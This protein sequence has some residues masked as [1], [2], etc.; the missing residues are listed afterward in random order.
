MNIKLRKVHQQFGNSPS[1][2]FKHS[3][4]KVVVMVHNKKTVNLF[5]GK[6]VVNSLVNLGVTQAIVIA[7][8]KCCYAKIMSLLHVTTSQVVFRLDKLKLKSLS[9]ST[10]TRA[11]FLT[12]GRDKIK[13]DQLKIALE[14]VGHVLLLNPRSVCP[15]VSSTQFKSHCSN[16]YCWRKSPRQ[17]V[18]GFANA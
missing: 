10:F 4:M 11:Q 12:L 8:V 2:L 14:V 9:N 15:S 3:K 7:T 18:T 17:C 16:Q 13:L 6:L 5:H 1:V